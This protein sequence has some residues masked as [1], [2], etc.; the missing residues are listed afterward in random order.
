M[1]ARLQ[2]DRQVADAGMQHREGGL[3]AREKGG[4]CLASAPTQSGREIVLAEVSRARHRDRGQSHRVT[5]LKVA[6]R[7]PRTSAHLTKGLLQRRA[8][9]TAN[10]A[11]RGHRVA[12]RANI[13]LLCCGSEANTTLNVSRA[14]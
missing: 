2:A 12:M 13:D 4:A 10:G 14:L 6:K 8:V 11:Y 5:C 3:R 9:T 1:S 7:A